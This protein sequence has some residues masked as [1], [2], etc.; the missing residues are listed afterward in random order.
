MA[1]SS[2]DVRRRFLEFFQQNQHAIVPSSSLVPVGDPTLL[3]VNA[4]MVQFKDAF[5]GLEEPPYRRAA[6]S[7]KCMRVSG[8][9]NDFENVGPSPRHHTFF[10]MLGN[11]SFGDYF[12]R[13]AVR[14]AWDLLVGVCGLEPARLWFTVFEGDGEIPADD[15]AAQYW[16]EVG[17]PSE[18]IL[19]FGRRDNFWQMGETGPCG[20]N[21]EVHYYM[22]PH[23][24]DSAFNHS[25]HVNGESG[26]TIELWNLVFMQFNMLKNRQLQRL[27]APSVDTGAGLERVTA[28][29]QNKASNYETDLFIPIIDHTRELLGARP[30]DYVARGASYRVIADHSRAV[31]F[32]IADGVTPSS[33]GR[34]YILRL[35]LRRAA[36]HGRLLGFREPFLDRVIPTVIELMGDVYP[37]LAQ[38][39]EIIL[40]TAR[41]EEERFLQTLR[42]GSDILDNIMMELKAHGST[43]IPGEAAFRLHD[44]YGFPLELT[45]EVAREQA[46]AVDEAGFRGAM[47]E[48][49]ERSRA[50]S[51]MGA[52]DDA[53]LREYRAVLDRLKADAVLSP[54][55]A[56]YEPYLGL[57]GEAT[58]VALLRDRRPVEAVAQGDAVEVVLD[59]THFYIESG[60]QVSDTG[61]IVKYQGEKDSNGGGPSPEEW[62]I[63]VQDMRQPVSGLIVHEGRVIIGTPRVGDRVAAEVDEPRRWDIMRNHTATHLLQ[64][65]LRA[66]LGNHV[67]QA[68][69]LVAPDRLR[70][71]F[72]HGAAL[73][74]EELERIET[75]VN[76]AILRNYPVEPRHLAYRE[77]IQRGAMALF[78]EKYGDVVRMMEIDGLSRELCGG[79]HVTNTSQ[80]GVLHIVGESSIGS[81]LRR[82]EAVT[83]RMAVMQ[84]Q[85][86]AAQIERLAGV[87]NATP[88]DI[89]AKTQS[90]VDRA[91]EQEKEIARLRR[92]VARRE[93]EALLDRVEEV[94]GV[95]VLAA[96]VEAANTDILRE[97][98]D[99]FRDRMGS[100]VIVLAATIDGKPSMVASVTPDLVRQGYD[101]AKIL[102]EVAKVVGGGG[103]GKPTLAQA[104]GKDAGR[105]PEALALVPGLVRR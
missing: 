47:E 4:G 51:V 27:P 58:V 71:D 15:E 21:S 82:I 31:T 105:I 75:G 26:I 68:G 9:H 86:R 94:Q 40:K 89:E 36:R 23:P 72:T 57:Y 79:T 55:G 1:L 60:G 56:Q 52:I 39:R 16:Q 67:Q 95:H 6:T 17:A 98:T 100:G 50:A 64:A 99:W 13:E 90:L 69:S 88:A 48:Q 81:G 38:R 34:G 37:E 77:A 84:F 32:L 83:G 101:A 41:L 42:V 54:S 29:L 102:R 14:F 92:E 78:T 97:L 18:R 19:R 33:E 3:F 59:Q 61:R 25:G 45:R 93:A 96:Q 10:E 85:Q 12:K 22:G 5:L 65:E 66:V 43:E 80:I 2:R 74:R 62:V 7:Q 35:I 28:V 49:S 76:L 70:F 63:E 73:T 87:L 24:E 11:F 91:A 8:K 30:E 104:G 53:A 20:P 46:M 103:G 44:T